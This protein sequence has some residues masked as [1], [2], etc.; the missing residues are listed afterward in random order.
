MSRI[1]IQDINYLI[2][3]PEIQLSQDEH[4]YGVFKKIW[5]NLL[6]VIFFT[7]MGLSKIIKNPEM[8]GYIVSTVI[9]LIL[10]DLDSRIYL[11]SDF[12]YLLND[13][14][15]NLIQFK[16]ILVKDTR[17]YYQEAEDSF[18]LIPKGTRFSILYKKNNNLRVI[19]ENGKAGWFK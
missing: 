9:A 2:D 19:L 17:M 14:L 13:K 18:D 7:L 1:S 11:T 16:E 4:G 6:I 8:R 15:E 12:E 3:N 5:I 10:N